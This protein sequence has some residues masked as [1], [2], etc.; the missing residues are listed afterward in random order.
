ML[1]YFK[2][3]DNKWDYRVKIMTFGGLD[4][5]K[6]I[7]VAKGFRQKASIDF[8]ETFSSVIRYTIACALLTRALSK[9]WVIR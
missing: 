2:V 6:S 5:Y 3:I 4:K 8:F 9:D 1:L 7:L